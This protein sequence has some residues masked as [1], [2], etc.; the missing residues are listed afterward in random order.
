MVALTGREKSFCTAPRLAA[1]GGEE[2]TSRTE[3]QSRVLEKEP[4]WPCHLYIH[5]RT[6]RA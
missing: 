1:W 4:L 3:E 6:L 5:L 2:V